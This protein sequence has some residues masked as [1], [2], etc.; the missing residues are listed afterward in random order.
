VRRISVITL[1]GP[2]L[3]KFI[4]PAAEFVDEEH[5]AKYHGMTYK[6]S[7]EANGD[8]DI[9]V[10]SSLDKLKIMCET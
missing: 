9:D 3:D 4:S 7:L 5:P 8:D 6:E 1:H 10:Q 2:E